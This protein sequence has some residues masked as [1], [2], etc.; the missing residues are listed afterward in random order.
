MSASLACDDV[1]LPALEVEIR[2]VISTLLAS[3]R[4]TTA[5]P[6]PMLTL[7]VLYEMHPLTC[8]HLLPC[9]PNDIL[10]AGVSVDDFVGTC[11]KSLF[12]PLRA[13]AS[14]PLGTA[15]V[16]ELRSTSTS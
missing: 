12:V 11:K 7:M 5:V 16:T 6:E 4:A 15:N 2:H 8:H 10:V 1:A 9:L 3:M 13:L 14:L